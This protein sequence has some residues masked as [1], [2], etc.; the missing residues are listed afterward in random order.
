[1][2]T[3][4]SESE[5]VTKYMS[6]KCRYRFARTKCNSNHG[7]NNYKCRCECKKNH[8]CEK[9]YVWNPAKCNYENG[10]HL[11]NIMDKII[12]DE[13]IKIFHMHD[14]NEKI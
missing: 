3:E 7:W 12:C 14:F 10:K 8:A 5:T 9:G 4:I 1:M 13:I 6:C 2:I 11:A